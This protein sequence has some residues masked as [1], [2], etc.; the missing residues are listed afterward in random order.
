M[1]TT[2]NYL[3]GEDL[4]ATVHVKEVYETGVK[5]RR[6]LRVYEKMMR[7]HFKKKPVSMMDNLD[8]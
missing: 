8:S 6:K 1:R 3:I 4:A 5:A 7:R 2:S